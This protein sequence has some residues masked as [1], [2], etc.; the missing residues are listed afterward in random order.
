MTT[1]PNGHKHNQR[2]E[3]SKKKVCKCR[4]S[5]RFHGAETVEYRAS[6]FDKPMSIDMG[7]A[8]EAWLKQIQGR[9]MTC[10][11]GAE[12]E[13]FGFMGYPHDSGLA[14]K[15]GNKWWLFLH[16]D[17]CNYEWSYWKVENRAKAKELEDIEA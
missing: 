1:L 10:W 7:N 4:C 8:I 9:V 2:C 6:P 16:C 5:G 17:K 11:C 14:D 12:L 13:C 3:H 15:D